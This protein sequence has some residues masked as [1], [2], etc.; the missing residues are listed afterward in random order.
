MSDLA[1]IL[2]TVSIILLA[3]VS[4]YCVLSLHRRIIRLERPEGSDRKPC[5]DGQG[6][7]WASDTFRTWCAK[8]GDP[9]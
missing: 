1:S 8:C 7:V 4:A 5:R 3:L 6:H 9:A 2:N